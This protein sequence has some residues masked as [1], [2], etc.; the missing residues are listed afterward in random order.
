[1]TYYGFRQS[2]PINVIVPKDCPLV[3]KHRYKENFAIVKVHGNDLN[4]A[5]LHALTYCDEIGSNYVHG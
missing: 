5:S 2:V 1:M 4:D 3:D